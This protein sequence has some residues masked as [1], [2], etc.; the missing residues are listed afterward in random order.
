MHVFLIAYFGGHVLAA[1]QMASMEEC[2]SFAAAVM[3]RLD[4]IADAGHRI[5]VAGRVVSPREISLSCVTSDRPPTTEV[6]P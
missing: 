6:V 3:G 1:G 2:Q 5:D 4:A